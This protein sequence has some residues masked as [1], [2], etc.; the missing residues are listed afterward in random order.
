MYHQGIVVRSA[1]S[2]RLQSV[3]DQIEELRDG[4]ALL[5]TALL[6]HVNELGWNVKCVTEFHDCT[7]PEFMRMEVGQSDR[8]DFDAKLGVV[9]HRSQGH[10]RYA[11]L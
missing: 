3:E 8:N 1:Y 11:S 10:N 6:E 4:L 7:G 9:G 5:R 2:D